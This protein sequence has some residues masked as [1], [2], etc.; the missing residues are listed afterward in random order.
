MQR[1][2]ELGYSLPPPVGVADNNGQGR[3]AS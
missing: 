2:A 3:Q 1:G